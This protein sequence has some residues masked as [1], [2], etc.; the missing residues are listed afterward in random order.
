MI[1]FSGRRSE[2]VV[3][4]VEGCVRGR[5]VPVGRS[6]VGRAAR[7]RKVRERSEGENLFD[8]KNLNYNIF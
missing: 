5:Q 4:E 8:F 3:R 1:E 7:D 6:T 2:E